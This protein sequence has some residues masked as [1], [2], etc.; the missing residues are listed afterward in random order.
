MLDPRINI[1]FFKDQPNYK[2]IRQNFKAAAEKYDKYEQQGTTVAANDDESWTD[3]IYK[4]R[5]VSNLE[6]EI[7][8]YFCED[9]LDKDVNPLDF[10]KL[11]KKEYPTLS[12]MAETFLAVPSTSTPSERAFSK[13]RLIIHHTRASL[14]AEKI[15]ALMCLNSWVSHGMM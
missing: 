1:Q 10:W 6:T 13:G 2:D 14:S 15:R 8:K 5:K 11:Q 12:V 3:N 9:L 7:K 4:K